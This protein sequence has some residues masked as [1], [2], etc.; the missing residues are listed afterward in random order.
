MNG[1]ELIA[2]AKVLAVAARTETLPRWESGSPVE[3]KASV[4]FDPVTEADR[5]AE[6]S[7]RRMIAERFPNHGITG[8]EWPDH[9]AGSDH[10]WSLDPIDGT[11]SFICGLPNWVTLIA[12]LEK[13]TP[14]FGLVDAPCL[15]ETY[16]GYLGQASMHKK[17]ESIAIRTSSCSRLVDARLST[18]DPFLFDKLAFEAFDRLRRIARTTRFGHDGYAYARLAAGRI[19]YSM[20]QSAI[21]KL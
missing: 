13:G 12:L 2:F 5:A 21:S 4:G 11:R 9:G 18:T 15:D 7:M 3:N 1:A 17:N 14:V 6:Q 20:R 10:V 16:I 8:E 19:D